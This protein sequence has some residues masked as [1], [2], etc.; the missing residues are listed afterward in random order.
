MRATT[1]PSFI[2]E[3]SMLFYNYNHP[4]HKLITGSMKKFQLL[5]FVFINMITTE[6]TAQT[7]NGTNYGG[8]DF[9]PPD[10]TIL[11]GTFTNVGTFRITVGSTVYVA[12]GVPLSIQANNIIIEGT[13]NGQGGGY[14]G[15]ASTNIGGANGLPGSG[16]GGGAGGLFG[17]CV[18]GDGGAGGGYG[19]NGGNSGSYFGSGPAPVLGGTAYGASN[20]FNS[21]MGYGVG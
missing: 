5:L 9:T 12:T 3:I 21:Q 17:G 13:L 7:I 15:G 19:G 1:S 8:A 10:G 2:S 18:H 11:N 14:A 16:P 4:L 6:V 20:R